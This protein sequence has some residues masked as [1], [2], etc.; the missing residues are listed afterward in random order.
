LLLLKIFT[1]YGESEEWHSALGTTDKHYAIL[2]LVAR[3]FK[4]STSLHVL[5]DGDRDGN[6]RYDDGVGIIVLPKNEIGSPSLL[7]Q[8]AIT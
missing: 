6:D 7:I 2:S 1:V 3:N 4:K 5:N 8:Q